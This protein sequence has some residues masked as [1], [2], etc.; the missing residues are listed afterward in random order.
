MKAEISAHLSEILHGTKRAE[1]SASICTQIK[2]QGGSLH[3]VSTSCDSDTSHPL[4]NVICH[5]V[6][7]ELLTARVYYSEIRIALGRL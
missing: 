5:L 6:W 2:L 3:C 4:W 7:S 1:I